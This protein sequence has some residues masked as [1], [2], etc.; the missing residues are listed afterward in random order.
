MSLAELSRHGSGGVDGTFASEV[1]RP[2]LRDLEDD[3]GLC[4][5]GSLE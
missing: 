2:S 5:S 4:V 1:G 3:G